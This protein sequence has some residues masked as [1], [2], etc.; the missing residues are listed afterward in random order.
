MRFL[1]KG[2]TDYVLVTEGQFISEVWMSCG[3][4]YSLANNVVGET[5]FTDGG[6]LF[7]SE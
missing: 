6:T 7:T 1:A 5:V 3:G 2:S 4:D